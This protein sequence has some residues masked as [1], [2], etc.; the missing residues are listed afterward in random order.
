MNISLQNQIILV[1]GAS[2]GIGAA[3][4]RL[5]GQAG[6]K[7]ALHYHRSKELV[8]NLTHEI[9]GGAHAF[10]ADLGDPIACRQLVHKVTKHYGGLDV[11]VNNAGLAIESDIAEDLEAWL[12]AWEKT[13]NVNTRAAA[14]IS[15][16]ALLTFRGQG[17]GRFIFVS[18][19]A[20]FR[21]DTPEYL[22]Y[23]VSKA[24]MVALN[25]TLARYYGKEGITS[26]LIAPGFTKTDMAQQFIDRYGEAIVVDDLALNQLTTPDDIAPTVLFLAS[27]YMDHAT[28]CT[29]DINAGSYVH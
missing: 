29:I 12:S 5:L 20:A 27:G 10:Q 21:G 13:I 26:F 18:S 22:A 24:G 15:K 16:E 28:G 14:I 8:D 2:R 19:R 17:S 7:V 23:A 1:T 25:R 3:I 4:C 6:A 9:G 11:V